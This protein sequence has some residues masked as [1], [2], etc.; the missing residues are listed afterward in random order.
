M[1]AEALRMKRGLKMPNLIVESLCR[2]AETLA[3]GG[4]VQTAAQLV[5][6]TQALREEIGGGFSWVVE[7]NDETLAMLRS[8]LDEE[9]LVLALDHGRRLTADEAVALALGGR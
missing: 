8:K 7:A 1:M 5:G 9:S 2:F 3:V 6:A 4:Q